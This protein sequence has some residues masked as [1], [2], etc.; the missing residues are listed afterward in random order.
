MKKL[1]LILSLISF[2][3]FAS[4]Q[5]TGCTTTI[6]GLNSANQI[7]SAGQTLCIS[8]TGTVTGLITVTAGGSVCNEGNINSSNF[9]VAGG[10]L[11]NY[12]TINVGN[13]MV[14]S[15]GTFTNYSV[16]D[17]DSLLI[18]DAASNYINNGTQINKAFA[19]AINATATN[20]GNVNSVIMYDSIGVYI[21]NGTINLSG[22]M[23]TDYNSNF[24]NNGNL[25]VALDLGNAHNSIFTNNKFVTIQ[26]DFLNG[27]SA[28][29][30]TN[31]IINVGRN[32]YNEATITGAPLSSCG[33]FSITGLSGNTGTIGSG[34]N[35]VDICD[36]GHPTLGLDGPGGT[37][38]STTTYCTCMNTCLAI[39]GIEETK[40]NLNSLVYPNPANDKFYIDINT[41][42][43]E[44]I[45]I[46]I[47][48]MLGE[49]VSNTVTS[50]NEKIQI[51]L[52]NF[53]NGLYFITVKQNNNSTTQKIIVQH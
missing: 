7:I 24:T 45:E 30:I 48:N 27:T 53:K 46:K 37:I 41:Q 21:N 4:A 32:W 31:C 51:N 19:V 22:S 43:N 13:L 47:E 26:R 34:S 29:F 44:L 9:W 12:G 36:V 16:T 1:I 15:A 39:V 50:Q 35:H 10:T 8:S 33:G 17:A 5:C 49:I 23:G 52:S 18:T 20:N 14:S 6:S 2:T 40:N 25:N 11:R 3:K 42:S 28:N 38:A